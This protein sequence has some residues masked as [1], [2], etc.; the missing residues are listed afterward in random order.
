MKKWLQAAQFSQT[1][2]CIFGNFSFS[3]FYSPTSKQQ[4]QSLSNINLL[5]QLYRSNKKKLSQ[6]MREQL[7]QKKRTAAKKR[8]DIE[9][10][11]TFHETH[12]NNLLYLRHAIIWVNLHRNINSHNF[13]Y[14]F[15]FFVC[16][17]KEILGGHLSWIYFWRCD[18]KN[19]D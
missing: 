7:R 14:D 3:R 10:L 2:F 6:K 13:F 12:C 18:L 1:T 15:I 8:L 9:N 5:C 4:L 16:W 17:I 19:F 11:L